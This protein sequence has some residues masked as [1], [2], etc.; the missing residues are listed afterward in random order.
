AAAGQPYTGA[1]EFL[2]VDSL[3]IDT[4]LVVQVRAGRAAGRADLADDLADL[5]VLTDLDQD[6]REVAVA[7]REAVA[8]IDLDHATVATRPSGRRHRAVRGD[9][10]RIAGRRAEIEAG[11][12]GGPAEERIGA[13]AKARRQ[14]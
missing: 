2:G 4:G 13:H 11:V 14:L 12:H 1:E 8:V 10:H 9:A 6:R 7:R 3:A 5:H